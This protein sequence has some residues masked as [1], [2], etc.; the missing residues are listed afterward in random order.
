MYDN[1]GKIYP[2]LAENIMA[3]AQLWKNQNSI[4][5]FY[6]QSYYMKRKKFI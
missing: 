1:N 2:F 4:N 5:L 6:E 3:P